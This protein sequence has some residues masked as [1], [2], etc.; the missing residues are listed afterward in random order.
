MPIRA[1]HRVTVSITGGVSATELEAWL[2]ELPP[3]AQISASHSAGDRPGESAMYSLTAAWTVTEGGQSAVPIGVIV[4][5]GEGGRIQRKL[6]EAA[7]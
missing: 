4:A 3:H 5:A 2:G 7:S 1:Q 6:K